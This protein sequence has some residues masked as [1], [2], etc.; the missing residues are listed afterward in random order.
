MRLSTS[1]VVLSLVALSASALVMACGSDRGTGPPAVAAIV[2]T[3][4]IGTRLAVGRTAQLAAEARDADG[5]VIP[6]VSFAWRSSATSVAQVSGSGAASG[7]S[8]GNVT[9]TASASGIDGTIGLEVKAADLAGIATTLD[10]AYRVAL[11]A[12]LTTAVRSRT[13]SAIAECT[14]GES[15]GDF[16]RIELCLASA[17]AEVTAAGDASDRANLATLALFLDHIERLLAL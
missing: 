1:S 2:V 9:I 12:A 5:D 10:D 13:Q 11:V 7:S 14:A 3:S 16:D 15:A 17:R 6:G 8:A 4:P